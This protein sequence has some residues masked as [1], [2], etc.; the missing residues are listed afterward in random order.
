M[1]ERRALIEPS[2]PPSMR[3]QCELLAVNR[4]SLYYAPVEPDAEELALMRRIDELHLKRPFFGSRMLTQTLKKKGLVINRKH[5]Q[6]L[7]RLMGLESLAP[8]PKTSSTAHEH[9]VY[10]YL[11]R[12]VKV[13]RVN[14][15]W[16]ADISVPQISNVGDEG[17]AP[18]DR[19]AGAD[20]KPP[21]AAWAKSPGRERCGKGAREASG[22]NRRRRTTV[23]C[24]SSVESAQTTSKPGGDVDPGQAW[25]MPAYGPRGVRHRGSASSVRAPMLNCGNLRLRCEGK[26]TSRNTRPIVPMRSQGAE[27][28]VVAMRSL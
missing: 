6:R 7:M 13:G 22:G 1:N 2:I 23:N 8:K 4:S 18:R 20:R 26:G 9:P 24:R 19:L 28:L 17:M 10:P 16:A 27:R 15:V 21:Q 25:T 14:Q 11:L 12:E 3:R 5:V